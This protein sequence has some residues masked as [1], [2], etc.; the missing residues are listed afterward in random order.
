MGNILKVPMNFTVSLKII[1]VKECILMVAF[2][3]PPVNDKIR[4]M[5]VY[6]IFL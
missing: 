2:R 3:T 4:Q 6:R 1:P 5:A